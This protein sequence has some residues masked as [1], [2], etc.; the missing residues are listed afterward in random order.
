MNS[1]V[2]LLATLARPLSLAII[3]ALGASCTRDV[4]G[5]NCT[6]TADCYLNETCS[7]QGEC[8]LS[9]TGMPDQSVDMPIIT[10]DQSVDMPDQNPNL[11]MDMLPPVDDMTD[12][13][14]DDATQDTLPLIM[15]GILP[16]PRAATSTNNNNIAVLSY[17]PDEQ[18]GTLRLSYMD[19]SLTLTTL[20][21]PIANDLRWKPGDSTEHAALF[22][23]GSQLV[24]IFE[25]Y[26][27][28]DHVINSRRV[29]SSNWSMSSPNKVFDL[30]DDD[31]DFVEFDYI[32]ENSSNYLALRT[33]K[34]I[35]SLA[36]ERKGNS[37][38]SWNTEYEYE[39]QFDKLR[40]V[41]DHTFVCATQSSNKHLQCINL[42][43]QSIELS[44]DQR[45]NDLATI[46]LD[47]IT[48]ATDN[49][50]FVGSLENKTNGPPDQRGLQWV[51]EPLKSIPGMCDALSADTSMSASYT[52]NEELFYIKNIQQDTS[53]IR[54]SV[55]KGQKS[56][57]TSSATHIHIFSSSDSD[58]YHETIPLN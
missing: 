4:P 44:K 10:P 35:Q 47:E 37:E 31:T 33:N 52:Q 42:D 18:R 19:S 32:I 17:H 3:L 38:E 54:A 2:N 21:P 46:S 20:S 55:Q 8:V 39:G 34:A 6:T 5:I 48:F 56:S 29:D 28:D 51:S 1:T 11:D 45:V 36:Q 7:P 43:E 24:V 41:V 50:L 15:N 27:G 53:S 23:D 40:Y 22:Q 25:S 9:S 14:K 16:G 12:M 13:H 30:P 58:I 57:I 26:S 49:S